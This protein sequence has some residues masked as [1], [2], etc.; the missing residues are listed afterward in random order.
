MRRGD[1]TRSAYALSYRRGSPNARWARRP[2]AHTQ[3]VARMSSRSSS[4]L[5]RP[6]RPRRGLSVTVTALLLGA[7]RTAAA[8][9]GDG[10]C[11]TKC[12]NV[13]APKPGWTANTYVQCVEYT[14][15][16]SG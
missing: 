8:E 13:P 14:K 3:W 4:Q 1:I 2:G 16:R 5:F 10:V 12:P 11:Q 6:R 9:N 7:A 15:H